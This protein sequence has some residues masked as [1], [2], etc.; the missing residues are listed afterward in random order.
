VNVADKAPSGETL[1]PSS[2]TLKTYLGMCSSVGVGT[3]VA[4]NSAPVRV[5]SDFQKSFRLLWST[6]SGPCR[7]PR[8]QT[9]DGGRLKQSSERPA[10]HLQASPCRFVSLFSLDKLR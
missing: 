10:A 3:L 4:V 1:N 6:A 7:T 9:A 8:R 2:Y 5:P